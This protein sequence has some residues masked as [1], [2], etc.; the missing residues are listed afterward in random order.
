MMS[1]PTRSQYHLCLLAN[2]VVRS[3]N[4]TLFAFVN[5]NRVLWPS[6]VCKTGVYYT[7]VFLGQN[8]RYHASANHD[9]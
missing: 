4:F 1:Q 2:L 8:I 6:T 9:L 3:A 7:G 5:V